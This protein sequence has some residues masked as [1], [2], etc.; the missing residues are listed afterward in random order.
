MQAL[1]DE[2]IKK[3]CEGLMVKTLHGPSAAYDIA[4]RSHNWLKVRSVARV[5]PQPRATASA[6]VCPQLKK[7]YLE[8]V[9]DSVDAVV[10]GGYRGRGKR[11]GA[12]GG[13]LLACY[14]AD[15]DEYQSLCKLGTGFSD[16]Q[17]R[18]LSAAL[19][20]R[21]IAG[22]RSYYR[23]DPALAPDAWFAAGAVWE[24]R[25]ADLSLSPAHRAAA[26]LLHGDK[27]VSLRF[28]RYSAALLASRWTAV[29]WY[30]VL[31]PYYSC[32]DRESEHSFRQDLPS[33]L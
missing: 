8:G 17:L 23:F 21:A 22:P 19:Q 14:D 13:F 12:F 31:S 6:S 33:D 15:A 28:P 26:G 32:E 20:Q 5:A 25:C 4:R 11:A 10:L 30:L 2:S 9:G 29:C 16:E 1:L 18:A 27:G 3:S 7:D 24:V